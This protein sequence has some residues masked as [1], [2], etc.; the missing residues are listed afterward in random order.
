MTV[1]GTERPTTLLV[2]AIGGEGGGVL[3]GWIVGA[4]RHAGY[5]V[6]STSIP[7]VAQRTGAT[8]YYL[9]VFPVPIDRLGGKRPVLAIYPGVGDVDVMVASEFVEAGRAIANGFITPDRTVLIASTHRVYA[10]SERGAMGDGR[11]DTET[12]LAAIGRRAKR[13]LLAD[14]RKI[15]EDA[16]VSLNA[17]LLG[18]LAAAELLPMPREA[19][20]AA[21]RDGGIAVEANLKGFAIGYSH[22]FGAAGTA[23]VGDPSPPRAVSVPSERLET[24]IAGDF[25]ALTHDILRE[26][27]RRLTGYQDAAYASLYLDRLATVRDAERAAGGDG[28]LTREAGRHLAL[29]MAYEDVIRVAQL[30]CARGRYDRIR[31]EV[32]AAPHEPVAVL[33]YFKPGIEEL[34]AILPGRLARALSAA[35]DRGGW[36]DRAH[37]GLCLRTTTLSGFLLLRLVAG[38]R[39]WRPRSQGYA[40]AQRSIDAWLGDIVAACP[41]GLPLAMEVVECARLIKGYGDTHRRGMGSVDRIRNALIAPA[42][43]GDLAP[44]KAADAIASARVAALSDPTGD[45]LS[46]VLSDV[47]AQTLSDAAE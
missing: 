8:T 7:G 28:R 27:A 38:L 42:L 16:G 17:V 25:P 13:A 47:S 43:A 29:R 26:G 15:A 33:E 19:Y 10:N 40:D 36:R 32:K 46:R 12:L 37:L 35:A 23:A 31:Q 39:R 41:R 24:R 11:Y 34:C 18:V 4:A 2:S 44:A 30:K 3:A 6:Q 9:E 45:R 14:L 5:P 1:G 20:E 21:I 22:R